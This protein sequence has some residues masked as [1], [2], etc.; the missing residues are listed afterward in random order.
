MGASEFF[1]TGKGKTATEAFKTARAQAQ[2][3]HGHGGYTGSLAEKHEFVEIPLPVGADPHDAA[4]KLIDVGDSR[5]DDKWGPAGCVK[6]AEGEWL[7]F[8]WASS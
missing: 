1:T 8:G 5:V 4:Q 6:V 7:F 2:Y 3:D